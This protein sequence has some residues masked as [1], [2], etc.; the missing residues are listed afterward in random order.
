VKD[1]LQ[2]RQKLKNSKYDLF[3]YEPYPQQLAFINDVMDVVG[4]GGVLVAEAC[5]G[6]GKTICALASLLSMNRKIIY[7]TRTHEQ[8]RQVLLEVES[9]NRGSGRKFSAVNLA[10]RQHLCLNEKCKNLSSLDAMES[11]RIL[12]ETSQCQYRTELESLNIMLPLILSINQLRRQGRIQ[13]ICPYFLSRKA[14]E[15]SQVIVAPYQYVFNPNIRSQVGLALS[16]KTLV[17]DEAHNAEQIGEDVLSDTLSDRT[18]ENAKEELITVSF[19]PDFIDDLSILLENKI[20][21]GFSLES[22]R[23]LRL[24]LE[25]TLEAKN[26]SMYAES[27]S[28]V[29]DEI[30]RK[31]IER[32]ENSICYLNGLL[33]FIKHVAINP[34]ESFVAIYRRSYGFNLVDFKCLDASL[35]IKPVI[36]KAYG[37]LIMSGTLSPIEVFSEILGLTESENR[38]YASIADP[39]NIRTILDPS[40]TTRF[41]E[42]T[43]EMFHRYGTR[44]ANFATKIPNGVLVFFPQRKLMLDLIDYWR[45]LKFIKRTRGHLFLDKKPLFIEGSR[46]AENRSI[47][48]NYKRTAKNEKGAILTCVFR[49]RNSEGSN[50]PHEESRGIILIGVPF[51]DYGDPIVKAKIEYFEKRKEGLGDRWYITDAFRAANQALGRGIRHRDD[52]CNFIL[53]DKRYQTH[54]NLI[55]GWATASGIKQIQT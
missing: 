5:N 16:G 10:S 1:T 51:A 45:E 37:T 50:F 52:W 30:R 27:L 41:S 15:Q 14:A 3:P 22:G 2:K 31:K 43:K 40:V 17:F 35:A 46:V 47:V 25:Q 21:S 29:V 8:V 28:D 7:A 42:R 13:R 34:I 11:C 18:L 44:L 36:E 19:Q 6:F 55:S 48:E 38:V 49:G 26:L 24:D 54:Q 53:M 23:N 33:T 12:R 9:I 4:S 39:E 20:S 32:G